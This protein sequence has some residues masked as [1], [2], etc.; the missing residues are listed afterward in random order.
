VIYEL[1]EYETVPGRMPAL[2]RRFRDHTLE[3]FHRHG[4]SVVFI[5]QTEFGDNI[6][7]E[8]VYVLQFE[9]HAQLHARWASF[10]ADPEWH[11]VKADS[12]VDGPIVA[13]VKR[14][15]LTTAPFD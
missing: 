11:K 1:R 12:E 4:L 5:S 8:L 3:L 7:N 14:R 15:L 6:T 13:A 10:L 2:L 9:D